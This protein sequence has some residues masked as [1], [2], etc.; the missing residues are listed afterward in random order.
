MPQDACT[1]LADCD[2]TTINR[3]LVIFVQPQ[4]VVLHV[5][6]HFLHFAV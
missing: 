5:K 1:T 4:L 2:F 6:D 3:I